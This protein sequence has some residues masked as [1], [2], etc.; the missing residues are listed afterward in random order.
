MVVISCQVAQTTKSRA[1]GGKKNMDLETKLKI[2]EANGRA[3]AQ[4]HAAVCR[5]AIARAKIQLAHELERAEIVFDHECWNGFAKESHP[6][7][8]AQM[9]HEVEK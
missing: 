7:D 2:I 3:S 5:D 1:T 8:L 6:E 9:Q 4:T